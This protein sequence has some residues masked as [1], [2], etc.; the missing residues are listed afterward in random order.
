[1]TCTGDREICAI[2][3][4]LQD[5]LGEFAYTDTNLLNIKLVQQKCSLIFIYKPKF[6]LFRS[7]ASIAVKVNRL[8][9]LKCLNVKVGMETDSAAGSQ[10]VVNNGQTDEHHLH[11]SVINSSGNDA[12]I[13]SIQKN[14]NLSTDNETSKT[15]LYTQEGDSTSR[16]SSVVN[17]E[18]PHVHIFPSENMVN[19][20]SQSPVPGMVEQSNNG[21]STS[22]ESRDSQSTVLQHSSNHQLVEIEDAREACVSTNTL[23]GYVELNALSDYYMKFL[24]LIPSNHYANW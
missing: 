1:M 23:K 3:R 21:Y 7:T 18:L 10:I 2:S 15:E 22:A 13:S 8:K 19:R 6:F 4:G 16:K 20:P 24:F 12:P 11:L 9:R 17:G 5:I 14:S